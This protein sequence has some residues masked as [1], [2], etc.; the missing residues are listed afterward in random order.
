MILLAVSVFLSP[1]NSFALEP[2]RNADHGLLSGLTDDDHTI[3][4][5]LA[6]RSGGQ[7]VYGGTGA[8]DDLTFYTTSNVTK[9]S[10]IFAELDCSGNANGGALTVN[11]SGV[12][13]CS[14]DDGGSG[15]AFSAITGST[16]TT[17]A[18]VVGTGA[19]LGTSG[20]GT[21][22]ATDGDSATGFF[23]SGTLDNAR[24]DGELQA[25]AG[26]TSATDGLPYFTG[27]G[28]ASVTTL[29][30]FAR[31]LLDDADA[32]T[33]RTTLGAAASTHASAH[34][35]GGGDEIATATPGANAIPKAEAD[36]DL[37]NGWIGQDQ[38][39]S[40]TGYHNFASGQIRLP[41]TTVGSLP[42][43][44]SNTGKVFIVTDGA[45]SSDCSTG[46]GS[47]RSICRSNGST[48]EALGGSSSGSG[49]PTNFNIPIISAKITG[50]FV[51]FTPPTADACSQAAQI[52]GGDG[53]W[54]LLFDASTDECA[55]FQFVMPDNYSSAPILNVDFSMTSGTANEVEFEGAI[56]CTT[57]STDT[58]DVGTASFS[59][60]ATG[61]PTTVA[62]S[63]G[64]PYRQS[65]T[66]NDDSCAAG[67]D[68]WISL[69]TDANDA[70]ND[71]ATGD[72]EVFGVSL[73]YS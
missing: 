44:A 26:L 27:S 72:R 2:R 61:T 35:N 12:L 57:P 62:S 55:A 6:G 64:R 65:I 43:A 7:S 54:R 51:V 8:G 34:Q 45:S 11:A 20:S 13:S 47:S 15:V 70:T 5:L 66:L 24:L 48:Y 46:S 29:T 3:Y 59:N 42:A 69:S 19:S 41:E 1:P 53:N 30:S 36:G 23:S 9:G 39:Y 50:A 28:T 31:S 14:D 38:D 17:A 67:D 49:G 22:T 25:L 63:A 56:M 60:V 71:D 33:A 32:G 73:S 21:I 40:W 10:Y 4:M 18:M 37:A 58:A 68:V 52:D 16:N